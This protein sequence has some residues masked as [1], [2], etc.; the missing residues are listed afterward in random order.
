MAL[1]DTSDWFAD[2]G[3]G[4]R[5]ALVVAGSFRSDA[6]VVMGHV[7]WT[8]WGAMVAHEVDADLRLRQALNCLLVET[9]SG[10]VLVET[11]IGERLDAR[12]VAARGVEGS[13]VLDLGSTSG[14][15]E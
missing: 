4:T 5:V 2:L 15:P 14:L 6:G 8:T 1:R 9:P 11:G 12:T 3:G 7:P 10:R 13:P